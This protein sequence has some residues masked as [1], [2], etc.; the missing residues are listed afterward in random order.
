MKLQI[1][2]IGNSLGVRIPKAL[3]NQCGF[4]GHVVVTVKGN[5]LI[6]APYNEPR[7]GWDEAF[8]LMAQHGDDNLL[9]KE[10][11]TEFDN[12]EWEW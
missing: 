1:V 3:L 12:E 11:M 2:Q 4:K 8:K 5:T 6:L 10:T 7:Q 9:D